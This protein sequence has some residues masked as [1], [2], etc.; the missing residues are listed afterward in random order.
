MT[1]QTFRDVVQS[2]K[3]FAKCY[4][5]RLEVCMLPG[6]VKLVPYKASSMDAKTTSRDLW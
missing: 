6:H 5:A 4:V 2:G 1:Q 3:R